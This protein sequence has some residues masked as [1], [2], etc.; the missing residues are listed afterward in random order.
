MGLQ[1]ALLLVS[2]SKTMPGEIFWPLLLVG[3]F[4]LYSARRVPDTERLVVFNL[5]Q[6]SKVLGPGL[7]FVWPFFQLAKRINIVPRSLPLPTVTMDGAVKQSIVTGTYSYLIDD[8]MKAVTETFDAHDATAQ[9]VGNVLNS[10][11]AQCTVRE[12]VGDLKALERRCLDLINRSSKTWGV[13]VT[14]ITLRDLHLP[15]QVLRLVAAL[16]GQL[17]VSLTADVGAVPGKPSGEE[18]PDSALVIDY[19]FGI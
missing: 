4:L 15:V 3:V 1:S 17:A 7:V 9:L 18:T 10:V 11:L 8:P 13:T 16:P 12:S 14:E 19:K 6:V 5:G 2:L